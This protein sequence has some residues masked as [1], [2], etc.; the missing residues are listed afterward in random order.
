MN[1]YLGLSTYEKVKRNLVFQISLKTKD[2]QDL[3]YITLPAAAVIFV[4]FDNL[5]HF[6]ANCIPNPDTQIFFDQ[7]LKSNFNI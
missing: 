2:L 1:T 5:Q 4:S 7:S 6:V 3:A